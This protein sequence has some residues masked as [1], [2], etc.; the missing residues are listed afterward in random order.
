MQPALKKAK[1]LRKVYGSFSL[2]KNGFSL[3][4]FE[5]KKSKKSKEKFGE[6]KKTLTFA[7][8]FK[9]GVTKTN[10]R[11]LKDWKQQQRFN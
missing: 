7:L 8:P 2:A 6:T 3:L 1:V 4:K 10:K 5:N 9:N 11:S